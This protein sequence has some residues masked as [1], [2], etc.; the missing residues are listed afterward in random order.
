MMCYKKKTLT[1][2]L[3]LILFW[4]RTLKRVHFLWICCL[5]HTVWEEVCFWLP[6]HF[7]WDWTLIGSKA[8]VLCCVSRL[9][10]NSLSP[11]SKQLS[12]TN[13][14][15][16]AEVIYTNK[17][18]L[19]PIRANSWATPFLWDLALMERPYFPVVLAHFSHFDYKAIEIRW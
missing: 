18:V 2:T 6:V 7:F 5:I 9:K 1:K 4:T 16:S 11:L 19:N 8:H 13:N 15:P 17:S 12:E 3:S 10:W 14:H